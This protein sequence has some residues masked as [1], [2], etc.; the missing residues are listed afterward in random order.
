M[1]D[2][3]LKKILILFS[4]LLIMTACSSKT[5]KDTVQGETL[6]SEGTESKDTSDTSADETEKLKKEGTEETDKIEVDKKLF[7]TEIH[8]PASIFGDEPPTQEDI[9]QS[10]AS[11]MIQ[12]GKINPDGSVTYKVSKA[13]HNKLMD[14]FMVELKSTLDGLVSDESNSFMKIEVNKDTSEYKV[15]VDPERYNEFES[16]SALGLYI[17]S[18]FY[19]SVAGEKDIY[20]TVK[21]VNNETGEILNEANS[22][23]FFEQNLD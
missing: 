11:G 19:R 13:Q 1:E 15:Y 21:F 9:N 18:A 23:E 4:L 2:L 16:F 5:V 12:D 14:N 8:L 17:Q 3:N 22:K 6:E 10:I 20:T 7:T